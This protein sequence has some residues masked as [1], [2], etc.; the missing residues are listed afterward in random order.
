MCGHVLKFRFNDQRPLDRLFGGD[1][2]FLFAKK[3]SPEK[4]REKGS[5]L[6]KYLGQSQSAARIPETE[7]AKITS[8]TTWPCQAPIGSYN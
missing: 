5:L 2:T 8:F 3:I 1:E 4:E 7:K 6:Q